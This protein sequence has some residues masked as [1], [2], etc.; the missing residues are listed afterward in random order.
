MRVGYRTSTQSGIDAGGRSSDVYA[1]Q[2]VA[3]TISWES[4]KSSFDAIWRVVDAD[5]EPSGGDTVAGSASAA[6]VAD[7]LPSWNG[8]D[9][10]LAIIAF[11]EC[12]NRPGA[13]LVP[14][15]VAV[16]DNDGS[17]CPENPM[18]VQAEFALDEVKRR[19]VWS[20]IS[21]LTRR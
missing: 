16:F 6:R 4:S 17:V 11:K 14:E 12:V 3:T 15:R 10:K 20:R 18:P 5:L 19:V 13:D 2:T 8:T 7:P 1:R 21:R 9:A